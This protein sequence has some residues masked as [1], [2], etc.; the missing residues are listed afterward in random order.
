[1]KTI[2]LHQTLF[3]YDGPQV[4]EA[5]DRIGG[6]YVGVMAPDDYR[7]WQNEFLLAG[8]EPER[9]RQFRA[10]VID[11]RTLLLE[12]APDQRYRGA[13]PT[14]FEDEV[15]VK[16]LDAGALDDGL[17]PQPGFRL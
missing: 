10:G 13:L 7:D 14:R 3:H 11:L 4:F 17:L 8:V 6:H 9:L 2:R 5:R 15:E 1:M 12:S 16:P